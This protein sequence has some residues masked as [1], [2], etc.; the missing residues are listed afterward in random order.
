MVQ[1]LVT[2]PFGDDFI[3]QLC[4]VDPRVSAEMA[5]RE[6]RRWMRNEVDDTPEFRAAVAEQIERHLRPAEVIV[7]WATVPR[8]AL[9][10]AV[11]LKWIQTTSAGIERVDPADVAHLQLTNASG[12]AAVPMSEWV[13]GMIL[14]FAKNFPAA[15]R[16][17]QAH[18]WD[19]RIVALEVESRTCGIVGMGAIGSAVAQRARALGMR[20]IATRRHVGADE[21]VIP[22][23][24]DELADLLL[25]A[26][27]LPQL[28][29]ESDYVVLAAPL[30]EET[31]GMIGAAQLAAM[32]RSAVLLNVG[33]GGLVDEPAL[34]EAL[35]ANTIAGAALDVFE[36][37]PLPAD[38]PLWDLPNVVL[39]PHF[40]AGSDRYN[41][42]AANLVCDNLR[43]YLA[44]EPLFNIVDLT[45]GY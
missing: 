3:E 2:I 31:Q 30:T 45:R 27:G 36:K 7:G 40:S 6:L 4:A 24:T 21:R 8:A 22:R 33:R 9:D 43:R 39:T 1:V 42:R 26:D 25:P 32:K 5:P 19:R 13:I 34:V 44:G 14:M 38:S 20:I 37:E 35:K 23:P 28:L 15:L 10:A 41:Q 17:Q 29:A 18:V 12:L 16:R 11:N